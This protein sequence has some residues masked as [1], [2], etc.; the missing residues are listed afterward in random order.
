MMVFYGKNYTSLELLSGDALSFIEKKEEDGDDIK[1]RK[2]LT[3]VRK[4][5]IYLSILILISGGDS[6][7]Y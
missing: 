4:T 5:S 7:L 1:M 6:Y 3:Q 2:L